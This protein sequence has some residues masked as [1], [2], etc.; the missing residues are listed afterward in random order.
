METAL[1]CGQLLA[2]DTP[3]L[4]AALGE[5][6]GQAR[7]ETQW[8][9]CEAMDCSPSS[10]LTY[11][12]RVPEPAAALR[13]EALLAR[14]LTGEPLAYLRGTR[15][16]YSLEFEVGPGVLIPRPDTELLVDLCLERLPPQSTGWVLDLGTGSG[17]VAITLARARPELDVVGVE[18]S[19][20]AVEVAERNCRRHSVPNC[21]LVRGSWLDA[22]GG[23]VRLIAAN[24]PYVVQGDAR[25]SD[26]GL[27]FEPEV[28]LVGGD[29]GLQPLRAILARAPTVL[30][31]G[32]AF[33]TEH[34]SDQGEACRALLSAAGLRAVRTHRDLAGRERVTEGLRA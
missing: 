12:E 15:E 2:R 23:Q 8:L 11:L 33:L 21:R 22:V 20:P 17:V 7:R 25:L 13:Y 5:D 18:W 30:A 6:P 9:L 1:S 26:G 24:P 32:G 27:R 28:A 10:L 14:R 3:R 29:D 34:G 19:G 31:P 16:F 4:G